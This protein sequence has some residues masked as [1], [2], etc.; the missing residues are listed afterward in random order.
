MAK[1]QAKPQAANTTTASNL[2]PK[3]KKKARA[4]KSIGKR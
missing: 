4:R 3:A 2:S 1:K